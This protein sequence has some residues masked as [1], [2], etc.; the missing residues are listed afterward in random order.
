MK[1]EVLPSTVGESS[2][3]QFCNGAV[4]NDRIAIDAG[5]LGLLWPMERQ[6]QIRHV[7]LSHSHLDHVATLPLFLD[8]VYQQGPDCP[9]VYGGEATLEALRRH[10]FNEQLWPDFVRLSEEE[11]PFLRLHALHS[12]QPVRLDELLIT[13]IALDHVIPTLGFLVQDGDCAVAFV[14]DTGPTQRVWEILAQTPGLQAVFLE[15]S[16]P[17]SHRW[18][19]DRS[20]HLCTRMF[21]DEI[22]HIAA[23]VRI[24]ACHL[25]PTHFES[26]ASEL[27][28][29]N[30]PGLELAVPGRVCEFH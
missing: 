30:R 11:T 25:K 8:N 2:A 1:V 26:I 6:R 17:N 15:A 12:E 16:F 19:A 21:A 20:G 4:V 10:M 5:T 9:A 27:D 24:I 23:D 13:P 18:L 22:A 28:Q 14:S 3:R 29:L 7:L